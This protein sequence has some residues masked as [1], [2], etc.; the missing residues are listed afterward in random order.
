MLNMIYSEF[1]KLKKTYMAPVILIGGLSSTILMVIAKM[2]TGEYMGFE[3]YAYNIEMLNNLMLYIILFSLIAAYVFSREFIDKTAN[4]LYS[5]PVNRIKIFISKLITVY[6][7]IIFTYLIETVSIPLSHY[8]LYGAFPKESLIIKDIKA[9]SLSMLFQ[10]LLAPI[11]I[12]IGN[13]SK[14]IIMPSIYG[15]LCFISSNIAANNN[16]VGNLKYIPL[17]APYF[18]CIW[19]YNIERVD[20]NRVVIYSILCFVLFM[21]VSIYDFYKMDIS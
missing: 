16:A 7:L 1:L 18:S 10:F 21:T 17:T 9:N 13:I 4:V 11:P 12:L 20:L 2:M 15:I 5:Y 19:V 8:F 14:N 3:K 6:I